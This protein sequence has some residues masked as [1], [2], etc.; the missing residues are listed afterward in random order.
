[1]S[2]LNGVSR[3]D[4]LIN[5]LCSQKDSS[6]IQT[7]LSLAWQLRNSNPEQ[8]V[9]FG[10]EAIGLTNTYNDYTGL[11]K[12]YG[13]VGV[14]YR[15]LGDYSKSIDFYFNGLDIAMKYNLEEEQGYAY[16]NIANLFIYQ[17][18]HTNAIE[19][20]K[21]ATEI[22]KRI[23][24]K[25]MLAYAFL[26]HGRALMLVNELNPALEFLQESMS[27]RKGLN[28]KREQAVC[29]K[30]IG[31]IY[32]VRKQFPMAIENYDKALSLIDKN[33]EKNLHSSILLEKSNIYLLQNNLHSAYIH[34]SQGLAIANQIGSSLFIR[35]ASQI[36]A[37]I[38]LKR[39]DYIAAS[40]L[41]QS[42]LELNDQLYDQQ[43]SEKIFLM[44]YQME[45]QQKQNEIE[46]LNRDN[47]IKELELVKAR[48]EKQKQRVII[49]AF[50][51]GFVII[52]VFL[53]I[54]SRLFL[55]IKIYN[56]KL[57]GKNQQIELQNTNLSIVNKKLLESED[58]L[59]K[60]VQT[61]DK[62]FSIIAH[63]LRSPFTVLIGLTEMLSRQVETLDPIEIA[64]FSNQLNQS[65]SKLLNLIENLLHWSRSQIGSIKLNPQIISLSKIVTDAFDVLGIQAKSKKIEL[66]NEVPE[67]LSVFAD[68]ESISI[69]LRNLM[70]NAI[71][72]TERDG[73]V[74]I[75]AFQ[76]DKRVI[77]KVSDTGIGIRPEKISIL[78]KFEDSFSTVGT[79]QEAGTGLG[80]L[81]CREFIEMNGGDISVESVEGEGTNFTFSIPTKT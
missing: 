14:A 42:I 57:E 36:L 66:R 52:F 21:R 61:K 72:Y 49:Y 19:N 40:K 35:D 39:N 74:T 32:F 15:V 79:N 63:D 64:E 62:L 70:S 12:A 13:F 60:L 17:E 50:A 20:I 25:S 4:S 26:Y 48:E 23:N 69:I 76:Q 54:I 58:N 53:L 43:L 75:S 68:Q 1:M 34:A 22:A 56:K 10:L 46:M 78:F 80:L 28:L 6:R 67:N 37:K 18:F 65:S 30:Y 33:I 8:S 44:E 51:A 11:A 47:T 27:I 3:I 77:V 71:K 29:L 31:D 9:N 55:Q 59:K 24:N 73:V 2:Y 7:L 45:R 5:T 41:Q 16:L 81:V 38:S